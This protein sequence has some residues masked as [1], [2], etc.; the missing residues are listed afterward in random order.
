MTARRKRWTPAQVRALGVRTTVPVAGEILG[1][2]CE[3]EAY[4]LHRAGQFPVPVLQVGRKLI[5][6]VQPILSLLGIDGGDDDRSH[7]AELQLSSPEA[8]PG[9]SRNGAGGAPPEAPPAIT[10]AATPRQGTHDYEQR[11]SRSAG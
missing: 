5:V 8:S 4:R 3:T 9:P 10:A 2:L 11:T 7:S 6:P 1:G